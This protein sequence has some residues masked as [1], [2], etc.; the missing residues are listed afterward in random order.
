[1]LLELRVVGVD[2]STPG[3]D[4]FKLLTNVI[5]SE[6]FES[7]QLLDVDLIGTYLFLG[8]NRK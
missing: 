8:R 7:S 6:E 4:R 3:L 2:L 5:A 1:M